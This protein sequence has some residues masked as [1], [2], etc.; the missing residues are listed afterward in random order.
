MLNEPKYHPYCGVEY[1][2]G[3]T[4]GIVSGTEAI[5]AFA[6][7]VSRGDTVISAGTR[8]SGNTNSI[9]TSPP[10]VAQA[11]I[12]GHSG[13]PSTLHYDPVLGIGR[14]PFEFLPHYTHFGLA[15]TVRLLG[16]VD[17]Q[18]SVFPTGNPFGWRLA[19]L[20]MSLV[21]TGQTTVSQWIGHIF[22]DF[23]QYIT[24]IGPP[25]TPQSV[26]I[27]FQPALPTGPDQVKFFLI[28]G[29]LDPGMVSPDKGEFGY[30]SLALN[31]PRQPDGGPW[32]GNQTNNGYFLFYQARNHPI[33]GDAVLCD[34][35]IDCTL[36]MWN[37]SL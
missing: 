36:H 1:D 4:L 24:T 34:G 7:I 6:N 22:Q 10:Y 30:L 3:D 11:P 29:Q 15:I 19:N 14:I 35:V 12:V 31:Y 28:T 25:P 20:R 9:N 8:A 23:Q 33:G 26:R 5:A 16:P 2:C 18:T 17:F 37:E 27:D 32:T 13:P 21:K